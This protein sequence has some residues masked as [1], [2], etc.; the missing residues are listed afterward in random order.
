MKTEASLPTRLSAVRAAALLFAVASLA[1]IRAQD[2]AFPALLDDF[3]DAT[4]STAGFARLVVDDAS[5]GGKSRLEQNFSDGVLAVKGEIA[6]ARGQPGWASVVLLLSASGEAADLSRFQGI[7]L[8]LNVKQGTFSVSANSTEIDNFD[9]HAKMIPRNR[10]GLEEV[11]IP[12]S[13]M[14]RAWSQQTPLRPETIASIS[15][16]VVGLE[17]GS[18]AWEIDELGFY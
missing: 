1:P 14:K 7:R 12:F 4:T 3:S 16:S 5:I 13:E 18:F 9:Y 15:L 10:G 11:R 8:R 17:A 2:A 6:P